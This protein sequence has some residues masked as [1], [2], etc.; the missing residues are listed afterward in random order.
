MEVALLSKCQQVLLMSSGQGLRV[1]DAL[2]GRGQL[3][4]IPKHFPLGSHIG[5][6][7]IFIYLRLESSSILHINTK[8]VL[9]LYNTI[10]QEC[11]SHL[12]K[13]KIYFDLL[14]PL[15]K[16]VPFRKSH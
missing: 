11:N 10:F 14:G 9:Y 7:P 16:V 1:P 5:K 8:Y 15:P 13:E 4:H 2:Q 3:A 6:K 12:N